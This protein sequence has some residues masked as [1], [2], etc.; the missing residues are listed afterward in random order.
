MTWPIPM[1]IARVITITIA[2][3]AT[4]TAAIVDIVAPAPHAQPTTGT[5]IA[6]SKT[7][8]CAKAMSMTALAAPPLTA[9]DSDRASLDAALEIQG[10]ELFE[11]KD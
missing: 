9:G 6:S 3:L 4:P 11:T 2:I 7:H 10:V 5:T 1:L 8:P